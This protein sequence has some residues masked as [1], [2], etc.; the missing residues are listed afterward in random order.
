MNGTTMTP[1]RRIHL[2]ALGAVAA[3]ATLGNT[4]HAQGVPAKMQDIRYVVFHRPGPA[5]Q[6]GKNMFEQAGVREHVAHYLQWLDAG[7]LALGGPHVDPAGGGMMVPVAGL[8]EDE[9]R[10]FAA[11]DPAVKGGTLIAEVRPWLIG[12][13]R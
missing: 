12:M 9:V 4:S 1:Y 2:L 6:P 8:A 3:L 7:K 13:S 11:D 5:W 10:R